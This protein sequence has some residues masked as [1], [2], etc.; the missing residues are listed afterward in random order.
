M[1]ND[2]DIVDV[3]GG[4]TWWRGGGGGKKTDWGLTKLLPLTVNCL[5]PLSAL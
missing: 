1:L 5:T 4:G 3:G 2:T